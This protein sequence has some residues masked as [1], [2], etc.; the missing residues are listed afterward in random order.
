MAE[1]RSKMPAGFDWSFAGTRRRQRRAG[2]LMTPAER[3]AWLEGMLDELL[4]L[5]GRARDAEK[6][7]EPSRP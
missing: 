5:V 4:P 3:L 1:R 7:R 6:K 2:L